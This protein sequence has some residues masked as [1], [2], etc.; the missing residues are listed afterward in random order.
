M[1]TYEEMGKGAG[2]ERE[3]QWMNEMMDYGRCYDMEAGSGLGERGTWTRMPCR[4]C[5]GSLLA[6]AD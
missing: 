2:N 3:S 1:G 5:L 6:R 4:L